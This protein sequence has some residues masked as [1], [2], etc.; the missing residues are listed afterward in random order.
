[1]LEV[2]AAEPHRIANREL[3]AIPRPAEVALP[4]MSESALLTALRKKLEEDAA[5]EQFAGAA[6]L[7][8]NGKPIFAK[9]YGLADR[10]NRIPG[11]F[12][13]FEVLS[14]EDAEISRGDRRSSSHLG[15]PPPLA[16]EPD[17]DANSADLQWSRRKDF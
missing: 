6:L 12:R 17:Q 7:A 1:P 3:R 9:A 15:S 11:I 16:M 4:H 10:E 2:E 13:W 5:A 8:K 14:G